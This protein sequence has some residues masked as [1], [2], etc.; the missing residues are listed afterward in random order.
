MAYIDETE[1]RVVLPVV[2][3]LQWIHSFESHSHLGGLTSI[4]SRLKP[5]TLIF[6]LADFLEEQCSH[7]RD[8]LTVRKLKV[9]SSTG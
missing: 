1:S 2:W 4:M 5:I 6:S 7:I 3:T 8:G 9:V